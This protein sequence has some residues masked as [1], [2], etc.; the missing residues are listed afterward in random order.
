MTYHLL[1]PRGF[2]DV[3]Q[4]VGKLA[5]M[6]SFL[7][8]DGA[9]KGLELHQRRFADSVQTLLGRELPGGLYDLVLGLLPPSGRWFPRLSVHRD[10]NEALYQLWLR[11]AP[12]QRRETT[13]WVPEFTDPRAHPHHKGPDADLL[14]H[15]RTKAEQRGADDVLLHDGT[16][17]A[18]AANA[19]VVGVDQQ[20]A[21]VVPPDTCPHL[22]SV[23]V[24]LAA[25]QA[26]V[27]CGR[28]RVD[29]L[30]EWSLWTASALHGFVPVT[31]WVRG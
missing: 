25:R 22:P 27:R 31:G 7:V 5:V 23:T 14:A 9:V 17:L 30:H 18:E 24:Q 21:L 11:P 13:L 29:E 10:G 28:I 16:Y 8:V 26:P 15:L 20:G 3:D 19:A 4:P 2:I 12:N 1:T 6:D